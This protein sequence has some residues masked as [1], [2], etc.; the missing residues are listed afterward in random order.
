[1]ERPFGQSFAP[2]FQTP[3]SGSGTLEFCH[4]DLSIL[5][6]LAY[7]LVPFHFLGREGKHDPRAL[8]VL[9]GRGLESWRL[10]DLIKAA[11]FHPLIRHNE[12]SSAAK[13]QTNEI[14]RR[15]EGQEEN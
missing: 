11:G 12:E 13:P 3:D 7:R 9:T 5:R 14:P 8:L 1:M 2:V 15:H 4:R 10:F 6:L